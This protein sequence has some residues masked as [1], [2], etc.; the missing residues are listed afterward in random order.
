VSQSELPPDLESVVDVWAELPAAL[1]EEIVDLVRWA[2]E[3][4]RKIRT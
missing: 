2:A 4:F 3:E 1:R